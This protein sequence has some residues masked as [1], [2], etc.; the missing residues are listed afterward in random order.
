M[1]KIALVALL[2][3]HGLIHTMGFLGTMGLAQFEGASRVPTNVIMAG[4]EDPIVR[5]LGLVWL[6]ALAGFLL[7]AVLLLMDT[8]AW[9][10]V[11]VASVAVSM[12]VVVLWWGNAP[13]G[14]VANA[15][16]LA[17]VILAPRLEGLPA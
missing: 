3:I 17:A 10:P 16:V 6:I 1:F 15:L 2:A 11:A 8:A 13:M 12:V 9:R 4:P 7:A 5:I 14:A